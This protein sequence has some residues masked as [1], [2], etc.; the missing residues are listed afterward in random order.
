VGDPIGEL[1]WRLEE[2]TVRSWL[3]R[4]GAAERL[5]PMVEQAL[6]LFEAAGD[7]LALC[8][9]YR[10]LGRVA[11]TRA[12]VDTMGKAGERAAVHAQRAGLSERQ[13]GRYGSI[14]RA[15]GATPAS[16]LLARL[17][18]QDE[19][20]LRLWAGRAWV[21]AMLGRI[22]EARGLLAALRAEEAE[23]TGVLLLGAI[24]EAEFEVELLAGDPAAA[25]A[26]GE[27]L[28]GR[29]E[30]AGS[31]DLEAFAG[32]LAQAHYQ[33]GRLDEADAWAARAAELGTSDD[34]YTQMLWRQARAKVLARRGDLPDAERLAHEAVAI[35]ER[36]EMLDAQ[37]DAYADLAEVLSLAGRHRE[38][39]QALEQ[40]LERYERKQNLVMAER[41]RTRLEAL[42]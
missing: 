2:G 16:E 11:D 24:G 10:A 42:R 18:E 31:R 32:R 41:T 5:V 20:D 19:Q 25:A 22:E 33:L 8:I 9:A 15:R 17:D 4:E 21:L 40:A 37:A 35:C 28:C 7:D 27:E 6:P 34:A 38:A 26:A 1:C 36:T 14:R 13:V 30:G 39:G 3:E 12:Q 23:R 29:L